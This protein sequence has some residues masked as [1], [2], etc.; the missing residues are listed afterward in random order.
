[1]V[2]VALTLGVY[3]G[4]CHASTLIGPGILFC[5]CFGKQFQRPKGPFSIL[6]MKRVGGC[7]SQSN[8][9][10]SRVTVF[11]SFWNVA[12]RDIGLTCIPR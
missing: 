5:S 7:C 8:M 3:F 2:A 12:V 6:D 10:I 9:T 4:P 1:M 11:L